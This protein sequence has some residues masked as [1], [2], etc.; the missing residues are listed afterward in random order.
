MEGAEKGEAGGKPLKAS[1]CLTQC[2][3]GITTAF[4]FPREAG[5]TGSH[6]CQ[7]IRKAKSPNEKKSK[8]ELEIIPSR[9]RLLPG[10]LLTMNLK[11]KLLNGG[12]IPPFQGSGASGVTLWILGFHDLRIIPSSLLNPSERDVGWSLVLNPPP[13]YRSTE[14]LTTQGT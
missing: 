1:C 14:E 9:D 8:M 2:R 12:L 11:D 7:P 3:L 6:V 5:I 13:K 4:P 10:L